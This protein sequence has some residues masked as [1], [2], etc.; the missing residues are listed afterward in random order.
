MVLA[1]FVTIRL[2]VGTFVV[3]TYPV[4]TPHTSILNPKNMLLNTKYQFLVVRKKILLILWM[5]I[6]YIFLMREKY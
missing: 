5:L 4:S 1:T 6:Y 3:G 2:R